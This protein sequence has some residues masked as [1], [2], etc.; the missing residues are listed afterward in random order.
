MKMELL[1]A[2]MEV[3]VQEEYPGQL[4]TWEEKA[5]AGWDANCVNVLFNTKENNLGVVGSYERLYKESDKDTDVLIYAHDDVIM[6]E[7]GWDERI[8][9]AFNDPSVGVV[10]FGGAVRHGNP[11][12]YKVPY[13][14]PHLGRSGYFSNVDDAEVHGQRFTGACDVAVL[15]GYVLAIRRV[16]LDRMGGWALLQ[17]IGIDF[18]AYDYAACALAHRFGYRCRVVGVRAHHLGGR[19]S[20]VVGVQRRSYDDAHWAY[21]NEFRNEM[22]W[23]CQ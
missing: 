9:S 12:L 16:L 23:T 7:E 10:G 19:T 13:H 20:T 22:P 5:T 11:N 18:I 17:R 21:Y 2:T 8:L 4:G 15:D 6:H 3:E 14:L 1:C